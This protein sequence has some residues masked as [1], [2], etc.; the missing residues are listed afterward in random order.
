MNTG[1]K[2]LAL[3]ESFAVE[4]E[5]EFLGFDENPFRYMRRAATV[6]ALL[7]L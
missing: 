7:A 5:V 4:K 3:A 2:P 1:R 6:R